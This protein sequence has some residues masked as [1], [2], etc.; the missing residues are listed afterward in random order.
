MG[1]HNSINTL[2]TTADIKMLKIV[3]VTKEG[4]LVT[5]ATPGVVVTHA[6]PGACIV[7]SKCRGLLPF[8]FFLQGSPLAWGRLVFQNCLAGS[9]LQSVFWTVA[10]EGRGALFL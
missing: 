9:V 10:L 2:Y 7:H 1:N 5:G 6:I 3:F 4:E 8:W